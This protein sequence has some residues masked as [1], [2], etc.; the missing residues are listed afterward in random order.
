MG[1][2]SRRLKLNSRFGSAGFSL[3]EI[4]VAMA[5]VAVLIGVAV[6]Y[7]GGNSD[8]LA[9]DEIERLLAV[10]QSVK[11]KAV[12]ENREYGLSI[13][14]N[15]YQVLLLEDE[16]EEQPVRWQLVSE[17]PGLAEYEFPPEVEV[18]L[19]IDGDN[20]FKS[21]EEDVDIFEE[22]VDIFEEEESEPKVE[23]PQI[24]FL[25]TGEQNQFTIAIALKE[26]YQA[27]ADEILFYRLQ[28]K[29]TGKLTLQ[30]PLPGSVFNDLERDYSDYLEQ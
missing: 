28:G 4:L 23:P 9:R 1:V 6:P 27:D 8:K 15:A 21:S 10:I 29:L 16:D 24:Y 3:I 12:I 30:G 7:L 20:I 5:I 14:E 25:S 19:A 22:D 11:D 26:I 17:Q 13:N 18:N 2:G